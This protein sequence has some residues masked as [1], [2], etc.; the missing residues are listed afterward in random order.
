M[1][2]L[3]TRDMVWFILIAPVAILLLWGMSNGAVQSNEREH[4]Q[5]MECIQ[6][7]G[8]MEVTPGYSGTTCI[9]K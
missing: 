2:K 1:S 8:N 7:G 4:R 5:Q 3:L 6:A 9:K